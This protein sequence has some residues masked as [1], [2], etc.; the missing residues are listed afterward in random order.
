M[1]KLTQ[2][3]LDVLLDSHEEYRKTGFRR[4]KRLVLCDCDLRGLGCSWRDMEGATII[5]CDLRGC[6]F[7]EANLFWSGL[8]GSKL[9][10]GMVVTEVKGYGVIQYPDGRL[11]FGCECHRLA[12]WDELH[13]RLAFE[14]EIDSHEEFAEITRNVV[15][16][17]LRGEL[18]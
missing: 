3:E 18:E 16:R 7:E 5:G 4:G 13:E 15:E 11:S 12:D 17:A 8:N 6:N 1:K 2:E 9:P 10:E 14:H